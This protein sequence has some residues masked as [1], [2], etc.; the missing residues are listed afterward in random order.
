MTAGPGTASDD[1]HRPPG[2]LVAEILASLWASD[3]PMTPAMVQ[4]ALPRALAYTT[5]LT[6]LQRLHAKGVVERQRHGRAYAYTPVVA[7]AQRAA[8]EMRAA[9]DSG[10]DRAAVLQHFIAALSAEDESILQQ[11]L[12]KDG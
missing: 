10:R 11:L 2:W 4:A 9:L 6:V 12:D 7:A 3:E 8:E 1:A 5:V